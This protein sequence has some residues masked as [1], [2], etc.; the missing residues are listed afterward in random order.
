M[1]NTLLF[2]ERPRGT[3]IH[4]L[5][6]NSHLK[7]IKL[8]C[9]I[10]GT[11]HAVQIANMALTVRDELQSL[12]LSHQFPN[13]HIR[14][15]INSGTVVAGVIGYYILIVFYRDFTPD[16]IIS[17]HQ[18]AKCHAIAFSEIPSIWPLVL[19]QR[20]KPIKSI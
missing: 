15:G 7:A 2:L 12:T 9:I 18:A 5:L 3:V 13:V 17:Y 4:C 11:R 19:N 10:I 1:T 14:A 16:L 6:V 20:A 8:I